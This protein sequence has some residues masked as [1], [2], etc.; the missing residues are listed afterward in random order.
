MA[1]RQRAA[2]THQ[3]LRQSVRT[4]LELRD[5]GM[6]CTLV[7]HPNGT[8]ASL[9][10][11][12]YPCAVDEPGGRG[13]SAGGGPARAADTPRDRPDRGGT[14][15][16]RSGSHSGNDGTPKKQSHDARRAQSWRARDD[17]P[18]QPT[19]A[20]PPKRALSPI[21]QHAH[22]AADAPPDQRAQAPA[23]EQAPE[24]SAAIVQQSSKTAEKTKPHAQPGPE[25]VLDPEKVA[26]LVAISKITEDGARTYLA[27]AG[28]D[29]RRAVQDVA[30]ETEE[31]MSILKTELKKDE[32]ARDLKAMGHAT[33][34]LIS[35]DDSALI[36]QVHREC[37]PDGGGTKSRVE[38]QAT[39]SGPVSRSR[40]QTRR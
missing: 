9:S 29:V 4:A 11:Y 25:E 17:P 37:A 21:P 26:K 8:L 1:V 39:G 36:D 28:G 18:Q 27:L 35:I 3:Q 10:T 20:V 32:R 15:A 19:I 40:A 16:H 12:P 14:P 33:F 24:P 30:L 6:T 34:F 5:A 2:N 23:P 31:A 22:R 13:G 7:F 38:S